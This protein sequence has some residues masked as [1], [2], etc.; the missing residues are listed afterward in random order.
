MPRKI[1][2]LDLDELRE[3]FGRQAI[4]R[5]SQLFNDKPEET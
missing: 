1:L 2:H 4:R 3:R 5:G